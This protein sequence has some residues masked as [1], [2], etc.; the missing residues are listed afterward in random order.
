MRERES[1]HWLRPVDNYPPT[2]RDRRDALGGEP[3]STR[4]LART[5]R[6]NSRTRRNSRGALG[7]TSTDA[8]V[9]VVASRS[10]CA[11]LIEYSASGACSVNIPSDAAT[12]IYHRWCSFLHKKQVHKN[13]IDSFERGRLLKLHVKADLRTHGPG[14][15][16][17]RKVY[18][19][20][21]HYG[22]K[23]F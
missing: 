17:G 15:S 14:T 5:P 6:S 18:P 23:Y 9:G 21:H 12:H 16:R 1:R 2:S 22:C 20:R 10:R 11:G 19:S 8:D 13:G 4:T 7:A 3:R